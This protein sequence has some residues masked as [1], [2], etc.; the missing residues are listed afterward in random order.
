LFAPEQYQLID[1]G[2]GRK[3]E[4]FGSYVIDRP[5][6]RAERLKPASPDRWNSAH[7]RYERLGDGDGQ[8]LPPG[9][10]PTDWMVRHDRWAM[11]IRPTPFGHLGIFPEQAE[12]WDWLTERLRAVGSKLRVLNLFAYTGGATLA[13][14]AAG[15]EVVHVDSAK[16]I[17]GW[18]RRN[19]EL[20]GLSG[21]P[22]RWISE[23][24]QTFVGRE[25]K[26]GIRY[27]AVILDPPSYGHGPKGQVWK[28][29]RHLKPLLSACG[30]L[31]QDSP[32]LFLLTC[33]TTS[34][35]PAVLREILSR[36]CIP[37]GFERIEAR[38]LMLR[39]ADGR[40]LPSGTVA[41]W[42]RE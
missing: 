41:R 26:R 9:A 11:E 22:I 2:R 6:P 8:W 20:S 15:A 29:E 35:T 12:N 7:S 24:A 5:C 10:L 23:D 25:V 14:A 13:S 40:R 37:D 39:S 27:D 19:A 32:K 31:M 4:R 18:A 17:V 30:Q 16:N 42:G 21:A 28:I 34:L 3:L 33:H 38:P 36:T 1:F